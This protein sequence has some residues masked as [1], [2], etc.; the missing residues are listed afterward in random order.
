MGFEEDA[1]NA[2]NQLRK[3]HGAQEL[4]LNKEIS[5]VA[6]KWAEQVAKSGKFGHSKR[7]DRKYKSNVMGE[8]MAMKYTS[9]GDD[10]TGEQATNQWYEEIKDWDFTKSAG[11]GRGA[12]GHF[13]QVVW[14][15]SRE[16]GIGKAKAKDGK[17]FVCANYSPAGNLIGTEAENVFPPGGK[18]AAPPKPSAAQP[19]PSA[20][21]PKPAPAATGPV[22]SKPV[23][24]TTGGT[25]TSISTRTETGTK[26]GKSYSKKIITKTVIDPSGK[27]TV[28]TEEIISEG[29]K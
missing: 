27:K 17:W 1:L 8:N 28:T 6:Q 5:A 19:K 18:G 20:A 13:T 10:F 4:V 2:H 23:A 11:T 7:E 16:F 3:K 25:S 24:A 26:N 14:A 12:T 21:Q 29:K 15:S 22:Q 9:S